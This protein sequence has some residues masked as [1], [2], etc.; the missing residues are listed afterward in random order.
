MSLCLLIGAALAFTL[1]GVCMKTSQ[2]L[3]RLLPTLGIFALFC[4]GAGLQTLAMKRAEMG[5]AYI[6]VLGLEAMLAF[7]FSVYFFDEPATLTRAVAVLFIAVG[8]ILLR[9]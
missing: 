8:I 2:G 3:T 4:L 6:F 9:R 1:G 7:L 5:V